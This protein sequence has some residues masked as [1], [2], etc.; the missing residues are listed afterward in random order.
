[1]IF[2]GFYIKSKGQNPLLDGE[3]KM[4]FPGIY[5]KHNSINY[6][7]MPYTVDSCFKY[8]A[9]HIKDI[10]DFVIWR[11]SAE[12]EWL[13][14]QRIRKL[15]AGLGK[16]V[17]TRGIDIESMDDE[18]KISRHIINQLSDSLDIQF[19]LS[20]NSVFD[21]SKTRFPV[22]KKQ[23]KKWGMRAHYEGRLF[24][25]RCWRAGRTPKRLFSRNKNKT[26]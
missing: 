9:L 14:T 16:H 7:V 6:A 22:K 5:F 1:L 26:K 13:T 20:L 24:C 3:F 10:N 11:D 4:T 8:I 25:Y 2:V 17:K 19:L 18:Q 15:K 21:I 12:T 23:K